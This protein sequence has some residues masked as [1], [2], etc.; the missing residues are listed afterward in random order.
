MKHLTLFYAFL[1]STFL[2][3][4]CKK[5]DNYEELT[6]LADDKTC[7]QNCRPFLVM[8][9]AKIQVNGT[10]LPF[11]KTVHLSPYCLPTKKTLLSLEIW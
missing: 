6:R 9:P 4:G 1:F 5:E 7:S 8:F 11:V 3:V 10:S 2:F